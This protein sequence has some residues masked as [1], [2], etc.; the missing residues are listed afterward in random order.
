MVT[1]LGPDTGG[2]LS[3]HTDI[4][5]LSFTGDKYSVITVIIFVTVLLL[6]LILLLLLLHAHFMHTVFNTP[7]FTFIYYLTEVC[8]TGTQFQDL[9]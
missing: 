2:P 6:L 5:K 8:L 4:D 7:N 3:Q 9:F 1:G